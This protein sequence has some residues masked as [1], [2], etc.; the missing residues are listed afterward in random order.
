M[1]KNTFIIFVIL[2]ALLSSCNQKPEDNDDRIAVILDTDANNELD[3]QHAIAYML[4]NLDVF[5]LLGIT[6]NTTYNGG[7]I[8]Q[9]YDEAMRVLTLF[10]E[11]ENI[12]VKRGADKSFAE[13]RGSLGSGQFDG[14]EAV[15]FI[16]Q[17]AA[18]FENH[19]L[20]LLPIGKLTNI[21]LA[22]E[23]EP[24]IANRIRIV[25]L[26]SNYPGPGEY[27]L[28]NDTSAL[29][30][31]LASDVPFEMVTVSYGRATGTWAILVSL[32]EIETMMP[33]KGPVIGG[34]IT[35]RHGGEFNN[36][37]AYAINLFQHIDL[38]DDPPSRSLYDL[39]AAAIL[40]NPAWAESRL[41]RGPR[42]D[43]TGWVEHPGS[44]R[45]VLLWENF[46]RDS[47]VAD[48]FNSLGK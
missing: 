40:K 47:I 39:A 41:V 35:G 26:G 30:Y 10:N 7:L 32:E 18:Q 2:A 45:Q 42:Y 1:Q 21:A 37:G 29:S 22:L 24:S 9:H 8:Q 13:I 48:L 12:Q 43:T 14:A 19:E 3:D 16:I 4:K 6:V 27:N 34:T 46:E 15:N 25:W 38:Y 36:F 17:Q 31:I 44:E 20:V 11:Q 23:K 28:E 33:G 5:N